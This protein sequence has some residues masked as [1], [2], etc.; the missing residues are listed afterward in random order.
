MEIHATLFVMQ[1]LNAAATKIQAVQK[2]RA[3]R[4]EVATMKKASEGGAVSAP[5][6]SVSAHGVAEA[7][8]E[9]A[10]HAS[11]M[12]RLPSCSTHHLI[13]QN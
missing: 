12:S 7:A 8:A 11:A 10:S 1:E 9:E 13:A 5:D 6:E 4:A 2:G 3:A